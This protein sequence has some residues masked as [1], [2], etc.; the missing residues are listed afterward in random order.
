MNHRWRR[1]VRDLVSYESRFGR[2]LPLNLAS[3]SQNTGLPLLS[4][5]SQCYWA[6]VL[7]LNRRVFKSNFIS[8]AWPIS[9]IRPRFSRARSLARSPNFRE[10]RG[11]KKPLELP[12]GTGG[13]G[14][15]L[16]IF[17]KELPFS[18]FDARH[19]ALFVRVDWSQR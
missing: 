8:I 11:Y 18:A 4:R 19:F 10:A 1:K 16:S 12:L 17:Y 7:W 15:G 14:G 3:P 9:F 2:L 6:W 5:L 13:V